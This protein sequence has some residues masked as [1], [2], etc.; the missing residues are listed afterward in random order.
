V[1]DKSVDSIEHLRC[2]ECVYVVNISRFNGVPKLVCHCT[3]ADGEIE[4]VDVDEMAVLPDRWEWIP[5]GGDSP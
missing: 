2:D 5:G 1:N 4:P 3:H